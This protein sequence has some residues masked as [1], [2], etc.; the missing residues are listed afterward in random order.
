MTMLRV[1]LIDDVGDGFA[2]WRMGTR[3]ESDAWLRTAIVA[4]CSTDTPEIRDAFRTAGADAFVDKRDVRGLI[5]A[6]LA[7]AESRTNTEV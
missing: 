5:A 4:F 3:R 1:V 7:I 6:V 2:D